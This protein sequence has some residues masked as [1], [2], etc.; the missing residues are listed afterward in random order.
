MDKQNILDYISFR[1]ATRYLKK[2]KVYDKILAI[3]DESKSTGVS[4]IEFAA[5]FEYVKRYRP[6][7][8]LECGTGMST[9]V[10][11][12]AMFRYCKPIYPE[13]KLISMESEGVWYKEALK[14]FDFSKYDFVDIKLSKV[15][16]HRYSFVTGVIYKNIPNLPY[17]FVFVDGPNY[18][19]Q[20]DMDFI[21]VVE[22]SDKKVG[23]LIDSRRTS[24]LAYAALLGRNKIL[25]HPFGF[26]HVV[27]VSRHDLVLSSKKS[28]HL[29]FDT[30]IP[31]SY[32]MFV[33][34][35]VAA[36]LLC[37]WPMRMFD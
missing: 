22:N 11:A 20:C 31:K 21:K 30:N 34:G 3:S 9:H 28:L 5:L 27:G 36:V 7:Y 23:A 24:A 2:N 32:N 17:D 15:T 18:K 16:D 29:T 13:I 8:V 6:Q 35:F 4:L 33:K 14:H 1:V 12:S 26:S 10:L 19:D 25:K 37:F